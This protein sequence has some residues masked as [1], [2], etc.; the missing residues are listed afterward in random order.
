MYF[1]SMGEKCSSFAAEGQRTLEITGVHWIFNIFQTK[2]FLNKQMTQRNDDMFCESD[3]SDFSAVIT[4]VSAVT[5]L[6]KGAM[7][8]EG[9]LY[10][11]DLALSENSRKKPKFHGQSSFSCLF[12]INIAILGTPCFQTNPLHFKGDN[13]K[14]IGI[15]PLCNGRFKVTKHGLI[16]R[17]RI[18][19]HSKVLY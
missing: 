3:F 12:P 8:M 13:D 2:S 10:C 1:C 16:A 11:T 18:P 5:R 19:Q 6:H 7:A 14:K 15:T 4:K 17:I 9:V